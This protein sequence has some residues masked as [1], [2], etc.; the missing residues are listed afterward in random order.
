MSTAIDHIGNAKATVEVNRGYFP[1]S[2][3]IFKKPITKSVPTRNY[4][5]ESLEQIEKMYGKR[6]ALFVYRCACEGRDLT[7][8]YPTSIGSKDVVEFRTKKFDN[9]IYLFICANTY[10]VATKNRC[11]LYYI[12]DDPRV[13]EQDIKRTIEDA[14]YKLLR[15]E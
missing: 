14:I 10:T 11:I 7:R 1:W 13:S 6:D 15:R 3:Y 9:I 5:G 4:Q 8:V 12:D 2:D